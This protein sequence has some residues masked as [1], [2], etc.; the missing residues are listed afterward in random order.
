[1]TS[2]KLLILDDELA[3]GRTIENIATRVG[4][5]VRTCVDPAQFFSELDTW[6]PSHIA[7]DLMMPS[8]DGVEVLRQLAERACDAQ[9]IVTSGMGLRVLEAARRLAAAHGLTI[10]GVL[11]KPFR[12]Q[13]L[14]VLLNAGAPLR[15]PGG[16]PATGP[17]AEQISVA[18]LD[19]AINQREFLLHFQPKVRT[20]NG[21]LDGFE[22]LLRWNH[23]QFGLVYP[24]RFIGLAEETGRILAINEL[25]FE[26]GVRW[27]QQ[28]AR[29]DNVTLELNLAP[30]SLSDHTLADRFERLCLER[31]VSPSDVILEVTE[32][33]RIQPGTESLEALTR[34][35]IKGFGLA[36]DDF[37][38]G[39]SSMGQLVNMPFSELKIDRS[40]VESVTESDEL[41]A[42]VESTVRLA[43]SLGMSTV[44]EGVEREQTFELLAEIGCDAAQGYYIARPMPGA[45]AAS[46]TA[47]R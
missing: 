26:M 35:R 34:L 27:K 16:A 14:H 19:R 8:M 38:I 25:V 1:M 6:T 42:V 17:E 30:A 23:P 13:A 40:F 45:Q 28:A 5:D 44:A 18:D 3:I 21:R 33:S 43:R 2:S 9:V 37:G 22:A 12:P 4:F 10:A 29:S 32:S 11:P 46:W 41:R 7:V 24:D 15:P 31:D 47:N 39:Y 20:I 36:I